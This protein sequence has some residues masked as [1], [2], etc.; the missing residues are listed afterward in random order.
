[1]TSKVNPQL[2][3]PG[4]G[5]PTIELLLA[6]AIFAV[7]RHVGDHSSFSTRF[8]EERSTIRALTS[9][10]EE[11]QRAVPMPIPRLRGLEDSSRNWSLWMVLD[12][13][14]ITNLLFAD[15]ISLLAAGRTPDS[16]V[17]TAA[18]KPDPAVQAEVE[19]DFEDSCSRFL[20]AVAPLAASPIEIP[21]PRHPHPW[22]GPLDAR[23]WHALA[24]MHMAVHRAQ[25]FAIIKAL[26]P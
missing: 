3:P 7:H 5:L 8:E 26:P 2:A 20:A 23:G 9:F 17:S 1:M 15:I 10:C 11:P 16:S 21:I 14:R 24:S 22:F 13:L 25:I 6:R 4:A 18:V 19:Q 12:H